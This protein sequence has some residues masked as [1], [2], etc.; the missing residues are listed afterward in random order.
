MKIAVILTCFNRKQKTLSCLKSLFEARDNYSPKIDLHIY[1]TD[2]GCT[3]GTADAIRESF[4]AENI[5][6][7]QGDGTLYWAGGMRFA[8]KEALKHDLKWDFFLL[9]NDDVVL[10][11]NCFSELISTHNYSIKEKG[12]AGLYSGIT[13]STSEPRNLTYSG[14]VWTNMM[15]GKMRMLDQESKPQ[16]CDVTNANILLVDRSVYDKIGIFYEGFIHGGA[17]HDYSHQAKMA[18]FPVWVTANC[19]G[20][21]DNDHLSSEELRQKLLSMSFSERKRYFN[22]PVNCIHDYILGTKRR[23]HKRW[24][25]VAIGRYL[26]LY[27]PRL[28]F[29]LNDIRS[30]M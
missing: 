7:L 1:L 4:P 27:C 11:S 19:C 20:Y 6:I 29:F 16:L 10:T 12:M 9:L 30:R 3:D 15:S 24:P 14:C 21:C 13:Y 26:N 5:T 23:A 22:N 18:G 17:D 8:W 2:D 28:Y 25:L